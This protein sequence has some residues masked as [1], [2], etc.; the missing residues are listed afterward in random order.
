MNAGQLAR[1]DGEHVLYA[2]NAHDRVVLL[3]HPGGRSL[4]LDPVEI[5]LD[6]D[7][8]TACPARAITALAANP[9][10]PVFRSAPD[11]RLT[12]QGVLK[13]VRTVIAEAG[14]ADRVTS[15]AGIPTLAEIEDR[16][17]LA[18]HI[19]APAPADLRDLALILN[20]YWGAFRGSELVGMCWD[21]CRTVAQGVEWIVRRAKN[22]QLG[23]SETVGAAGNPNP[24]LCPATALAEW[25]TA[26]ADLLGREPRADD[27]VF[28]RLDRQL[29]PPVALTRDGASQ[30][31]K[32]AARAAGLNG[33]HAS[34][35]LRAGFVTDALDAGATRE[36]VQR[37]GRWAN[38]RSIDPYYRKTEVWGRNN[39]SQRLASGDS[40][41]R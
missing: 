16:A 6:N 15:P 31:V 4:G 40:K 29:E 25:R 9:F 23:R 30:I 2:D 18:K 11:R 8:P 10:G 32:R 1:L 26:L 38:V 27:P 41:S 3:V 24:L 36:Q 39:P 35:S 5:P 7:A 19:G 21:D 13:I 14:L 22:D 28:V 17:R 34:H 20:L 37:H 12:R 33:D